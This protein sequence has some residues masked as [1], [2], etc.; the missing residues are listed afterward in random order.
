[1]IMDNNYSFNSWDFTDL[2]QTH[3]IFKYLSAIT[4]K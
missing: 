3:G 1:M 4:L 2:A